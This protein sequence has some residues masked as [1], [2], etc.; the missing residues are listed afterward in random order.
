MVFQVRHNICVF[1]PASPVK[2]SVRHLVLDGRVGTCK[3]QRTNTR[4][5]PADCCLHQRCAGSSSN[6]SGTE[7][8]NR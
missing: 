8:P 2:S 1:V 3:E 6:S 5:N 7:P 4:Q